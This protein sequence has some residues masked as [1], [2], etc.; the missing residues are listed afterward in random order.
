MQIG[1]FFALGQGR[2]GQFLSPRV[3]VVRLPFQ[4]KSLSRPTQEF[5]CFG[6]DTVKQAHSF[7][8][9]LSR[10]G[11]RFELRQSQ[12]LSAFPYEIVLWGESGLARTLALWDRRDTQEVPRGDH[13]PHLKR[14]P[15][16]PVPPSIQP[17]VQPSLSHSISQRS[18]A[19][20]TPAIAA[21]IYSF[22]PLLCCRCCDHTLQ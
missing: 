22:Y 8:Q 16:P 5:C 12:L 19:D 11:L 6:F 4:S 20:A 7:I 15:M 1:R 2:V 14:L 17:T 3:L 9:S 18:G 13:H 21:G 10:L